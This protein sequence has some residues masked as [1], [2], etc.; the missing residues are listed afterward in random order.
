MDY[1]YFIYDMINIRYLTYIKPKM[2]VPEE[3]AFT[4]LIFSKV[5]ELFKLKKI[6]LQNRNNG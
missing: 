3:T 2:H 6:Y 5:E 4:D 1:R